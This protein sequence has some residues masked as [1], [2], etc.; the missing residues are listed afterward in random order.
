M[1][2]KKKRPKS[3][4]IFPLKQVLQKLGWSQRQLSRAAPMDYNRVNDLANNRHLPGWATVVKIATTIGA[5]L[6]D[7]GLAPADDRPAAS[8]A[9]KKRAKVSPPKGVPV[10]AEG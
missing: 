4:A 1:R 6:G 9:E 5:S 8:V 3:S 10:T 7:F 2:R